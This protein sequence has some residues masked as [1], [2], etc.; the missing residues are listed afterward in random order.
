MSPFI[1]NTTLWQREIRK[2]KWQMFCKNKISNKFGYIVSHN[3][4]KYELKC[5]VSSERHLV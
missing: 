3:C 5:G 1:I 4:N 2:H